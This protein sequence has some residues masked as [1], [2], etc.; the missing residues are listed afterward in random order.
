MNILDLWQRV[1]NSFAPISHKQLNFIN[2]L[3]AISHN[4]QSNQSD[5]DR[6]TV[7]ATDSDPLVPDFSHLYHFDDWFESIETHFVNQYDS[8]FK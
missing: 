5:T 7:V 3:D 8:R 2:K 6:Q 1:D 4:N